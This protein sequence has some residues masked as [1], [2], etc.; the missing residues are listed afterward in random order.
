MLFATDVE[1]L[2][3]ENSSV[4]TVEAEDADHNV[5]QLPVEFFGNVPLFDW[6]S[7]VS[8]SLPD[9]IAREGSLQFV[10]KV[11]GVESNRAVVN[12]LS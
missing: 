11:G 5:Y 2:P 4:V 1:F 10:I 6:L 8:V 3:N 7:Q 9:A 12:L